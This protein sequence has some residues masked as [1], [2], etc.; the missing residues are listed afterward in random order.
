MS[1]KVPPCSH[2]A[3]ESTYRDFDSDVWCRD[4]K[5]MTASTLP[6]IELYVAPMPDEVWIKQDPF[7]RRCIVPKGTPEAVRYVKG[8]S[9]AEE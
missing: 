6:P 5:K 4:C 3:S 7:N 2:C 8:P 1:D 9:D